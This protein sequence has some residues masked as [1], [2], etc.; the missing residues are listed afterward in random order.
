MTL[1]ATLDVD[2]LAQALTRLD[3]V[4][5]AGAWLS[6]W[7][8]EELLRLKLKLPRYRFEINVLQPLSQDNLPHDWLGCFPIRDVLCGEPSVESIR[9]ALTFLDGQ[10]AVVHW[11]LWPVRTVA[12]TLLAQGA[13]NITAVN[14]LETLTIH[15]VL[16][17][18][19]LR[20]DG[21][22]EQIPLCAVYSQPELQQLLAHARP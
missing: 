5:P 18:S 7:Q 12:D 15:F 4:K 8:D 21:M 1:T 11:T 10:L 16:A 2:K 3:P 17:I 14:S 22:T 20:F 19:S 13:D 9:S 6:A